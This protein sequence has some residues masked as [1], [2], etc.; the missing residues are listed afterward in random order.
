VDDPVVGPPPAPKTGGNGAAR[1]AASRIGQRPPMPG[2]SVPR[3]PGG[4]HAQGKSSRH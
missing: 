4:V 3:T 2:N 1:P